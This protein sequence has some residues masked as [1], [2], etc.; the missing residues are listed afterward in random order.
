[1][2]AP[3]EPPADSPDEAPPDAAE[4]PQG[5]SE[6]F[7]PQAHGHLSHHHVYLCMQK[8]LVSGL[9]AGALKAGSSTPR[10]H[11]TVSAR[12]VLWTIG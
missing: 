7:H 11:M 1:M 4:P 9:A 3:Q 10:A 6:P 12:E 5:T 2:Q 8:R